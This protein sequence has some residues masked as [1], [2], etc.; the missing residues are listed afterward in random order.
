MSMKHIFGVHSQDQIYVSLKQYMFML[1]K[2]ISK[3]NE[4]TKT[5]KNISESKKINMWVYNLKT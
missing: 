5:T 2:Y 1:R 3:N 4:I